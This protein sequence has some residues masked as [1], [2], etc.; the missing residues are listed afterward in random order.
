MNKSNTI[1]DAI[2]LQSGKSEETLEKHPAKNLTF[3]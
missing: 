2:T 3:F 1:K